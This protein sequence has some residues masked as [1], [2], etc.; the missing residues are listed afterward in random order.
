M[1]LGLPPATVLAVPATGGG[2]VSPLVFEQ[3]IPINPV[4]LGYDQN[5][6][7]KKAILSQLLPTYSP[8]VRYPA[9]HGL[10]GRNMGLKFNFNYPFGW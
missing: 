5:A 9:F 7:D 10:P 1:L 8:I 6:L 4:F 3:N 2:G